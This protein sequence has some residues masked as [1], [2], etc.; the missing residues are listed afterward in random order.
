MVGVPLSALGAAIRAA[1]LERGLTQ[2][3]LARRSGKHAAYLSGVEHG[4]RN[5]THQTLAVIAAA[6]EMPLSQLVIEAEEMAERMNGG[7]PD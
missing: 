7:T 3:D 4:D 2:E 5:P 6:L 1:R